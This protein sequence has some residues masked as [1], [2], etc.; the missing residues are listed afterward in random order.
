[1]REKISA[2]LKAAKSTDQKRRIATLRLMQT[3][4]NDRETAARE[5]GRDGLPDAD[6]LEILHKM[7]RQREIAAKEF[8]E[9]GQLDR[10]DEERVERDIIAEFL[11]AQIDEAELRGICEATIRDIEAQGLRDIGRCMSTLKERYPGQ[12]DFVQA[13]CLVKD[14]LKSGGAAETG[15]APDTSQGTVSDHGIGNER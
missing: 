2:A 8:E 7:V 10:A 11:P 9:S 15:T 5:G 3:A 4:I 12:M 1:M 14:I 13:S 6:V